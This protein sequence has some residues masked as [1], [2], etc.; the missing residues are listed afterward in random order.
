[1]FRRLKRNCVRGLLQA[2]FCDFVTQLGRLQRCRTKAQ[3]HFKT[4]SLTHASSLQPPAPARPLQSLTHEVARGM[5]G[6]AG[7]GLMPQSSCF[8]F[9]AGLVIV[10]YK[11]LY[12]LPVVVVLK[13]FFMRYPFISSLFSFV[14]TSDIQ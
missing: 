2:D 8:L 1:M 9:F 4:Q 14:Q 3:P 5:R 7:V 11:S 12:M 6:A 13:E 10:N